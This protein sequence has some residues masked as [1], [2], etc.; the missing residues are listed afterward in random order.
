MQQ[1]EI[2]KY[3]DK[4]KKKVLDELEKTNSSYAQI[5]QR[6]NIRGNMTLKRWILASGRK[7]LLHR[8]KVRGVDNEI[9]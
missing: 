3:T 5:A 2:I 8:I 1:R 7:K 4:F 6:Y 9:L